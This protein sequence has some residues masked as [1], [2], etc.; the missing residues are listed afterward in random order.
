[1][2]D[3]FRRANRISIH[4]KKL[5]RYDISIK[6]ERLYKLAVGR[7]VFVIPERARS[8]SEQKICGSALCKLDT[9]CG[10]NFI[11]YCGDT[12]DGERHVLGATEHDGK[13]AARPIERNR[14]IQHPEPKEHYCRDYNYDRSNNNKL[15]CRVP[16]RSPAF[17][18]DEKTHAHI[19]PLPAESKKLF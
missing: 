11:S 12:G 13:I 3:A 19:I 16:A 7:S 17:P 4:I 14:I 8:V 15:D 18:Q 5:I 6:P 9:D 10:R 2:K 1:M